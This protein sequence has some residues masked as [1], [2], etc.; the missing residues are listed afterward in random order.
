MKKAQSNCIH[1]MYMDIRYTL[2]N[3]T[4]TVAC[5]PLVKYT[6]KK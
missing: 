3:A 1:K 6:K 4:N 5:N 2:F